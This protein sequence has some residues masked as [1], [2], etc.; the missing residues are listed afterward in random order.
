MAYNRRDVEGFMS[1]YAEDVEVRELV[2]GEVRLA[3]WA[4]MREAYA[5]QFATR[6]E[7]RA[8]VVSRQVL[9]EVVIDTE[10]VSGPGEEAVRVGAIY[11]VRNGKIDRVWFTPRF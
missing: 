2:S 1:W 7:R 8:E 3:G 6:P 11:R 9:G 5:V 10:L 4:A